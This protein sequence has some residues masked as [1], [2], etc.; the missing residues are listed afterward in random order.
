MNM[1]KYRNHKYGKAHLQRIFSCIPTYWNHSYQR[2]YTDI[3]IRSTN[4]EIFS[5]EHKNWIEF[6]KLKF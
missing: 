3:F 2:L 5:R 1:R 4:K 6:F